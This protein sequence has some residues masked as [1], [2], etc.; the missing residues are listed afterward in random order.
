MYH[1]Y[2]GL[3]ALA[4]LDV[5][6]AG[7]EGVLA[8]DTS[9]SSSSVD[10]LSDEEDQQDFTH[11][12]K[13]SLAHQRVARGD[14]TRARGLASPADE[15]RVVR[16][17]RLGDIKIQNVKEDWAHTEGAG[18]GGEVGD[19]GGVLRRLDPALCFSVRAREW[20]E[21]LSWRRAIV[22][23]E[24]PKREAWNPPTYPHKAQDWQWDD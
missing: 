3:A 9:S 21:S 2:L 22:G 20:L 18:E 12:E 19:G 13:P 23:N 10:E 17:S 5:G 1:A 11:L 15:G 8:R 6:Y 4:V 14:P 24:M 7:E 16:R